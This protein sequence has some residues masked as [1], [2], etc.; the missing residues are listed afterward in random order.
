[1]TYNNIPYYDIMYYYN[2]A[3]AEAGA[4]ITPSSCL[5][6]AVAGGLARLKVA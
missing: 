1:M 4:A 6:A 2:I 5:A 3:E